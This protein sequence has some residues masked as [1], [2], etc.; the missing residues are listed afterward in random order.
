M[1]PAF[2]APGFFVWK[3]SERREGTR[4]ETAIAALIIKSFNFIY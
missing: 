2:I 3:K 1:D 4:P